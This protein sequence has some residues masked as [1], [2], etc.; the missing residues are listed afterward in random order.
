LHGQVRTVGDTQE[1][2]AQAVQRAL[3]EDR[4]QVEERVS[5]EV[6]AVLGIESRHLD[7]P[8]LDIVVDL[9]RRL[10]D[11]AL[12]SWWSLPYRMR[13][14]GWLVTGLWLITPV[15]AV[16]LAL[17]S[18]QDR[19]VAGVGLVFGPMLTALGFYLTDGW[20]TRMPKIGV[21]TP[22]DLIAAAVSRSLDVNTKVLDSWH[23]QG[24]IKRQELDAMVIAT[25]ARVAGKPATAI[26]TT[27]RL[28]DDLG[29]G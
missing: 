3:I 24:V 15:A 28:V 27:D 26:R 1:V 21:T 6:Q 19:S 29:L 14:P 18:P 23:N 7:R 11:L 16:A 12:C 8:I 25:I 9:P 22:Q 5:R 13:R 2:V 4:A 17:G 20:R 10:P